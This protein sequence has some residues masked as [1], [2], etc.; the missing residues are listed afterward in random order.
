MADSVT[1]NPME[2]GNANDTSLENDDITVT[3]TTTATK[4]DFIEQEMVE[5]FIRFEIPYRNGHTSDD[6]FQ[7]HSKLLQLFTAAFDDTEIRIFDNKNQRI[8]DFTG[9]KWNDQAYHKSHYN[10]YDDALH[11]KTSIAHRILS[12]K[13]LSNLKREPTVLAF[14]K[15]S[16]TYLRA[17]FWKEDELAIKDIGFLVSYAPCKHSKSYVI[18]DMVERADLLTDIAWTNVPQFKLIHATPRVKLSG[19]QKALNTQ[20]YSVQVLAKDAPKMNKMLR[21]I[22]EQDHL[23]IPYN[24]KRSSPQ[25]VAKAIIHQNQLIADSYVIVIVGVSRDLMTQL[26]PTLFQSIQ[27]IRCVSDTNRTDKQ[28]R[29][30]IIVKEQGFQA[31]RKYVAANLPTWIRSLPTAL[32]A[33]TPDH[34]PPPQVS[35]KYADHDDDDSS[36]HASYM[37]SCAQSYGSV[38]DLDTESVFFYTPDNRANPIISYADAV[39]HTQPAFQHP[40]PP[41]TNLEFSATDRELR[42]IIAN[43]Q[44]EVT[45]LKSGI[46]NTNPSTPS[47]VTEV[48][49]PDPETLKL[50]TRMDKFETDM[51]RWMADMTDMIQKTQIQQYHREIVEAPSTHAKRYSSPPR[52]HHYDS[53]RHDHRLTPERGD[54]MITQPTD[55]ENR[56]S[57]QKERHGY[58]RTTRGYDPKEP[59]QLYL[60][61]GD[62]SLY[63][64]GQA[65]PQDYDIHGVRRGAHHP[66]S[67][68]NSRYHSR[69]PSPQRTT[70]HPVTGSPQS[71]PAEGAHTYHA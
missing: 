37:S 51:S 3:T 64:V 42:A 13:P 55:A 54:P 68:P 21:K 61:D 69:Q 67:P 31:T 29:W 57:H 36:G 20:A 12:K 28:G 24:M 41:G 35:Q 16:K 50:N 58:A 11:R 56:Q 10:L 23:Y 44:L 52:H 45:K 47:T 25:I 19:R 5:S 27:S 65:G 46:P 4:P 26:K 66:N 38:E 1:E 30:F 49:T 43:L 70:Q 14:L 9:E 2:E 63:P 7:L 62:G 39:K 6:D 22:Y 48:T 33:S 8:K 59:E 60:R 53:K 71:L 34:F 18:N 40:A 32:H 15:Q 17:H